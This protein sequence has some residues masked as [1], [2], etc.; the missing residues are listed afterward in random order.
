MRLRDWSLPSFDTLEQD[1]RYALRGLRRSPGFTATV[2]V[3][4]GLGIGANAAMFGV[5]DRL[6]FRP[7]A[8]PA[9]SGDRASRLSAV[10]TSADGGHGTSTS[11]HALSR[12][13]AL[14]DVV[15]AVRRRSPTQ[16]LAVGTVRRRASVASAPSARR[17]SILRRA[18]GARPIL[19]RRPRIDAARRDVAVLGYAYWQSEFGGRDVLGE[20][21]QVGNTRR[22]DHRRRARRDSPV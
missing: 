19:R 17:S 20:R 4:L 18:A 8:V 5:V 3:T 16:T 6:M 2:I 12:S 9:R 7:L 14:D 22:D 1:V 21:L 10:A 11:V 13:P 15:L